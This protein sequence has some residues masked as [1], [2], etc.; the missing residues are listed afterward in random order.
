MI[1]RG[2]FLLF[3]TLAGVMWGKEPVL[4]TRMVRS[5]QEF[6]SLI[7]ALVDSELCDTCYYQRG[8]SDFC[9]VYCDSMGVWFEQAGF[10]PVLVRKGPNCTS[11]IV[12][13]LASGVQEPVLGVMWREEVSGQVEVFW[14]SRQ[15]GCWGHP[16]CVTIRE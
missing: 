15:W 2:Q 9:R 11:P 14:R 1:S 7:Y 10:M 4:L 3:F 16:F 12:F 5:W 8:D 13:E 6:D